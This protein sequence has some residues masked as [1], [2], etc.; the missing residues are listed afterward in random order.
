MRVRD[1]IAVSTVGA[2][3]LSPWVRRGALGLWAGSV[4][5]DVDHYVWFCCRH[6][7]LSPRRAMRLFN[8]ADPPRDPAARALHN[9]LALL[10][11]IALSLRRRGLLAA[12]AGMSMH[13]LLDVTHEGRMHVARAAALERDGFACRA[14][15]TRTPDVETHLWRQPFVMPS[16]AT[17]NLVSLCPSCHE[18]AHARPE[19]RS[20][21]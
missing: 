5:I 11:V 6:R 14:C 20:W 7:R 17:E 13:V 9:P 16:Y 3:L 19:S 12:A 4:L 15:G 18:I 1:H 10:A 21:S 8:A 2:A